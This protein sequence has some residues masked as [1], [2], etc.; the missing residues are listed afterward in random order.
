MQ[1]RTHTHPFSLTHTHAHSHTHRLSLLS[2][3]L[4]RAHGTHTHTHTRTSGSDGDPLQLVAVKHELEAHRHTLQEKRIRVI[5]VTS[6]SSPYA[7]IIPP[8]PFTFTSSTWTSSRAFI[9]SCN[10]CTFDQSTRNVPVL[11]A[12]NALSP[13]KQQR[14]RSL[15]AAQTCLTRPQITS[16]FVRREGLDVKRAVRGVSLVWFVTT[17]LRLLRADP[18]CSGIQGVKT[19]TQ[20]VSARSDK[21]RSSSFQGNDCFFFTHLRKHRGSPDNAPSIKVQKRDNSPR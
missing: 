19:P 16:T 6:T 4:S 2:L 8:G 7:D 18:V 13:Y 15:D 17:D 11:E 12:H 3:S 9:K 14:T 10:S 20:T 1:A 21:R 5:S